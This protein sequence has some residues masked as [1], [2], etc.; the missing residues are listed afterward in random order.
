LN[1]KYLKRALSEDSSVPLSGPTRN[2]KLPLATE[3]L[4]PEIRPFQTALC[5]VLG[6]CAASVKESTT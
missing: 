4:D 6:C 3:R 5:S 2:L 1:G